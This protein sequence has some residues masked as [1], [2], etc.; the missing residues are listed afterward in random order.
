[1]NTANIVA[2]VSRPC[3]S[4]KNDMQQEQLTGETPVPLRI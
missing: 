2:R 3:V 4:E 1:M